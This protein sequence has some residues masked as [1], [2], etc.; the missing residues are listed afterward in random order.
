MLAESG[1]RGLT[2]R[3]VDAL[4]GI[5]PGSTSNLFRTRRELVEAVVSQ[6]LHIDY[7]RMRS[8]SAIGYR[9]PGE[10]AAAFVFET[11]ALDRQAVIA[12]AA[13]LTDPD[14]D[15]NTGAVETIMA[16]KN[17]LNFGASLDGVP[18]VPETSLRILL[19][20]LDGVLLD[21]ALHGAK[22][23]PEDLAAAVDGILLAASNR[24]SATP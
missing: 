13:P 23:A 14:A 24:R 6:L 17:L 4:A 19:A 9:S 21:G 20:F 12:R 3:A 1:S 15:N 5:P 7:D 11:L 16:R 18:E 2:H 10:F 8:L 22:F